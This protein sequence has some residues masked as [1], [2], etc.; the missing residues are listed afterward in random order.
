M[1]DTKCFGTDCRGHAAES[2][3][4]SLTTVDGYIALQATESK[5][6]KIGVPIG[7]TVTDAHGDVRGFIKMDGAFVHLQDT[8]F[9]KAYSAVSLRQSTGVF[10]PSVAHERGSITQGRLT[11]PTGGIPIAID[12]ITIGGIGVGCGVG[13]E[14]EVAVR[15]G[16]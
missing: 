7:I 2:S 15:A 1:N 4:A 8:S 13:N 6:N 5:A 10:P 12:G 16:V 11:N 9:S 3:S 14:D